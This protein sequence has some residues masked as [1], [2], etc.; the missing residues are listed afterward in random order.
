MRLMITN[1][2]ATNPEAYLSLGLSTSCKK[3]PRFPRILSLISS[4]L[5]TTVAKTENKLDSFEIKETASV[6]SG[7]RAPTLSIQR[8]IERIFKYANCSPSCFLLGYIYI[9]RF[10]E[11]PN[12]CLTSLNVHRLIITSVVVAAKFMD[13]AFCNNAYYARVGGISTLEMNILELNFLVSLDFR[14]H[15]T[16]GT[17]D[18]YCSRIEKEAKT[19]QVERPIKTCFINEWTSIEDAKSRAVVRRYSCSTL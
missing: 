12:I 8:Y 13:D 19:Y 9:E 1:T 18:A 10:L 4:I 6:F 3:V 7:T 17:F 5:E 2:E 11:Q 15:V 14:V 16:V